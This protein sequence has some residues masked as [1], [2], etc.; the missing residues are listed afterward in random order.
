MAR[1]KRELNGPVDEGTHYPEVVTEKPGTEIVPSPPDESPWYWTWRIVPEDVVK[2]GTDW[3]ELWNSVTR[4]LEDS[5]RSKMSSE[6][7]AKTTIETIQIFLDCQLGMPTECID[8]CCCDYGLY[9]K[10]YHWQDMRLQAMDRYYYRCAVCNSPDLLD[11]HHRTYERRGN[12]NPEDL[13]VLC[14]GCHDIF[15]RHGKLARK[16]S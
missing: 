12:E 15:H 9:L 14:R 7:A 4:S 5:V 6:A 10:T 11:V 16:E 13:I 3:I 2:L 8:L 1:P